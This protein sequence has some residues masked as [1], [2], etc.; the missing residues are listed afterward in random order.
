LP[1]RIAAELG[2]AAILA[3]LVCSIAVALI[4]LCFAE[5]GSRVTR[6]G[7][8]Y[9]YIE[10]ALGPMAGFTASIMYWLGYLALADAAVTVAMVET[11]TIAFPLLGERLPARCSSLLCLRFSLP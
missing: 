4:F 7:G 9:A 8:A 1:G 5:V 10:E 2:S 3:Y 6:S 11:M